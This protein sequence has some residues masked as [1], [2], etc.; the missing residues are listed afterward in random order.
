[1]T[2]SLTSSHFVPGSG[3]KPRMT[4]SR[5]SPPYGDGTKSRTDTEDNQNHHLVPTEK[6]EVQW[7]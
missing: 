5:P 2:S 1:M 6:D 7:R 3:T 4:S